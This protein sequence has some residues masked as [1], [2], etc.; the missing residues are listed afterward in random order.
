M[1]TDYY[2]AATFVEMIEGKGYD[3]VSI[4]GKEL[5]SKKNK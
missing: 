1:A 5:Y 2:I 4:P 3:Y